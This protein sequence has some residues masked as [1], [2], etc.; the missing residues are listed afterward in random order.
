[1]DEVVVVETEIRKGMLSSESL[2]SES[3]NG[4]RGDND[5]L[6]VG[7]Q[8]LNCQVDLGSNITKCCVPNC[9]TSKKS[10]ISSSQISFVTFPKDPSR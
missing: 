5:I 4:D 10:N 7:S 3:V 9:V 2:S 8:E 1:M 6:F